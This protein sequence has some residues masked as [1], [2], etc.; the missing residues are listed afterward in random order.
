VIDDLLEATTGADGV[1]RLKRLSCK[2]CEQRN[3]YVIATL[4]IFAPIIQD[5]GVE[6]D[7]G[8]DDEFELW[9]DTERGFPFTDCHNCRGDIGTPRKWIVHDCA[10]EEVAT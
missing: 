8:D 2:G 10:N 4:R 3:K 9:L 5:M 6:P 1:T 7:L